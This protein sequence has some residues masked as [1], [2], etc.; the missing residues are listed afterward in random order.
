MAGIREKLRE[1]MKIFDEEERVWLATSRR[2]VVVEG[3]FSRDMLV[4]FKCLFTTPPN[5]CLNGFARFVY[6]S[7]LKDNRTNKR[8]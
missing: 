1:E 6:Y 2:V 7:K 3:L 5:K 8:E 4:I